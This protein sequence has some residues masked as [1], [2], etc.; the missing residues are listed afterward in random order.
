MFSL[1]DAGSLKTWSN[2][3]YFF[4]KSLSQK[5]ISVNHVNIEENAFLDTLFRYT[6]FALLKLLY[7]GSY[8]GFFRSGINHFL[9]QRKIQKAMKRFIN[10]DAHLILS[11]S[12]SVA[13]RSKK[14]LLLFGDWTYLYSIT[15]LKKRSPYWFEKKALKREKAALENADLVVSL[16]PVSATFIKQHFAQ[17]NCHYLG[18]VANINTTL[19]EIR[20][21]KEK[22]NSRLI[23]FIGN[24]KYLDGARELIQA[25]KGVN[26]LDPDSELHIIGLYESDTRAT[27]KNM[28]HYGYLDKGN[29]DQNELYYN[30]I[31]KARVI[32]NTTRGWGAFSAVTEAMYCYTPVITSAYGEFMESYGTQLDFGEYAEPGDLT[33]LTKKILSVLDA[34]AHKYKTLSENAHKN[35]K[36]HTWENF[37]EKFTNLIA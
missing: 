12:F 2:V 33:A 24:R 15:I 14:P 27:G 36:A 13:N 26:E 10:S 9:V 32:V 8:H 3:P 16:F 19:N 1:G 18:N 4:S 5:G 7:P 34:P 21:R 25:F 37:T 31:Y 22:E 29:L 35:A 28:F 17:S 30:L 20:A 23:L 6:I 11:F